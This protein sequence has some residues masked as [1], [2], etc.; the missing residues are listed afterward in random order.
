MV[1]CKSGFKKQGNRCVRKSSTSRK[2]PLGVNIISILILII[3]ILNII[4]GSLA[5]AGG[6]LLGVTELEILGA[7]ILIM[8]ISILAIGIIELIIF[9]SLRKGKN[10]ARIVIIVLEIITI[11]FA[12]I[13]IF[14]GGF[15]SLIPLVIAGVIAGYLI[16]SKKARRFFK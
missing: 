10:W 3:G 9:F 13:S 11:I 1:K 14:S 16:F 6:S 7:F 12:L 5:I 8:G 2:I 15:I 4:I